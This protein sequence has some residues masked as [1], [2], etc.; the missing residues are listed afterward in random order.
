MAE[1]AY[2]QRL[3]RCPA[4]VRGSSPLGSTSILPTAGLVAKA[5][6]AAS[7]TVEGVM[8]FAEFFVSDVSV[9]LRSGNIGVA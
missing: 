1:L 4:R 3:G 6:L 7:A 5:A 8:D 9:N 2:A